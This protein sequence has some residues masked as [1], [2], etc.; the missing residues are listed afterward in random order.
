MMLRYFYELIS[1]HTSRYRHVRI[2]CDLMTGGRCVLLL[3]ITVLQF[4][5]VQVSVSEAQNDL[6]LTS[7]WV[8]QLANDMLEDYVSPVTE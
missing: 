6:L 5:V 8:K 2:N 7:D 4:I 3:V 1:V